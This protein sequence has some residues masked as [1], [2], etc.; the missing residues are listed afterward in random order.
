MIVSG[1]KEMN[2]NP[3]V[4]AE[5]QL[6][7][8]YQLTAE[9]AKG[10]SKAGFTVIVQDNYY[11]EKLPYFLELMA[12]EKVEPIVLTPNADVIRERECYPRKRA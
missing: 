9:V 4:E 12:P 7:L 11:G 2:E 1:Q 8:R 6:D 10:N 3:S 5:N